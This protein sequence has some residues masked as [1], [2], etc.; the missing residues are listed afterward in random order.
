MSTVMFLWLCITPEGNPTTNHNHFSVSRTY[1]EK[2]SRGGR[3]E[4]TGD[5]G[6]LIVHMNRLGKPHFRQVMYDCC[7]RC[8]VCTVA[9]PMG[10]SAESMSYKSVG[11]SLR[12]RKVLLQSA[13]H[14]RTTIP[15]CNAIQ[16]SMSIFPLLVQCHPLF[17]VIPVPSLTTC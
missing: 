4:K 14:K 9:G 3:A 13:L 7:R 15:S 11:Q 17:L 6:N 5:E 1:G 8:T 2:T 12:T 16:L 10:Q